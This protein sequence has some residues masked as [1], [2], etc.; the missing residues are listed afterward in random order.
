MG[1][2]VFLL[3]YARAGV[4]EESFCLYGPHVPPYQGEFV[5]VVDDKA[6]YFPPTRTCS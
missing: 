4:S 2:S 6:S 3:A 5:P 1:V